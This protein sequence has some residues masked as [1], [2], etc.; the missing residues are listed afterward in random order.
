M[1]LRLLFIH[2]FTTALLFLSSSVFADT[3][4]STT[5]KKA[6]ILKASKA[7]VWSALTNQNELSKWWNNGVKLEPFIGGQFYEPWGENQLATGLVRKVINHY[8]LF[9]RV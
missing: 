9:I 8:H 2:S 7:Q 6:L 5:I 1:T 3:A 4:P